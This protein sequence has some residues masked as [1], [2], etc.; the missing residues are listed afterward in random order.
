MGTKESDFLWRGH[1][2]SHHVTIKVN[3]KLVAVRYAW[4]LAVCCNQSFHGVAP[5]LFS[6]EGRILTVSP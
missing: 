4:H 1:A 5:V 6:I 3:R 2:N